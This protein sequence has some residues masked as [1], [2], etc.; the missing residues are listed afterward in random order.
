MD[1]KLL[2]LE[3][4]K[5]YLC[6]VCAI[7]SYMDS[8]SNISPF[9][10]AI[11]ATASGMAVGNLYWAQPLL[12]QIANSFMVDTAQGGF[13]IM[14]T[15][16]GYAL[17][18]FFIVPLGD[19]VHRRKLIFIMMILSVIALIAVSLA[20]SFAALAFCL[21]CLGLVTISGQIIMPLTGDISSPTERGKNVGIISGGIT[22]GILTARTISG[23]VADLFN[24]RAIYLFAA[25]IN[26][27][28]ALIIVRMIPEAPHNTKL[29]YPELLADV[30]HTLKTTP[31]LI[32]LMM[33][34]ACSF[35][36]VFNIFWTSIT[37]L[38]S[39]QP[40]EFSTFQIGLVSLTAITGAVA[41]MKVGSLQDKGLGLK[42]TGIF[43]ALSLACILAAF[44]LAETSII[45]LVI[46]AAIYSLGNQS[47]NILNQSRLFTLNPEKRSRL[48]TCFV[49]N[50]F[51]F[52]AIGSTLASVLWNFGGWHTAMGGG[53]LTLMIALLIWMYSYKSAHAFDGMIRQ[54]SLIE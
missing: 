14:A 8:K 47:V 2:L 20:P 34:A 27:L 12:A 9:L 49:V 22:I 26:L 38:L 32:P 23:L 37:F 7:I 17:G 33:I 45:L 39:S 21:A 5:A 31:T 30:F 3:I 10:I 6:N 48:N 40:F 29:S 43:L 54:N 50:N 18:L 46:I 24:W 25:A 13:L 44:F 52:C 19:V 28:L 53:A 41:A 11:L 35:G 51:I 1:R 42:A 16:I 36:I 4:Q 15:Q